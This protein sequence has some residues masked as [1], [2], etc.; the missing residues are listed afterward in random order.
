MSKSPLELLLD[1]RARVKI[2]K[3]IFRNADSTFTV[4]EM[5]NRIQERLPLVKKEIKR[6]VEIGLL[7]QKLNK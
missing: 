2:L 7:K 3:F 6:L 1:S 4:K 5:S